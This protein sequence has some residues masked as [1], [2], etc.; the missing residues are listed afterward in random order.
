MVPRTRFVRANCVLEEPG[1]HSVHKERDVNLAW[2][3]AGAR[4]FR[5]SLYGYQG[6][7]SYHYGGRAGGSSGFIARVVDQSG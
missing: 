3:L 2:L 6:I 1:S 5:I 7:K 4:T